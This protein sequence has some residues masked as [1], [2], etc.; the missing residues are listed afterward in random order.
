MPRFLDGHRVLDLSDE[1]GFLCG[2]MLADLGADVIKIEPPD[3][4]PA[5]RTGAFAGDVRDPERSITWLAYN[6]GKRGIT[7]DVTRPRG[8]EILDRLCARAD[9]LVESVEPERLDATRI[10]YA[11][12]EASHP[13]LVVCS[14]SPFGRSG[15]YARHRGGDLTATAMGGNMALTGDGDRAPLR[16]TMPASYFHGGA[17]AATGLL[18][19]L[20]AREAT[21]RGQHVDVSLQASVVAT[22]M[23][24]AS[25]WWLNRQDRGRSGALY[26]VGD[27]LQREVWPCRDGFVTYA[28]RGGPAR[29]PGLVATA[30][31]LAEE[32][33]AAP[34]WDRDWK[35]YNHNNL[36]QAEVDALSE[37]LALLFAR[38]TMRELFAGAIE[39]GLMLAPINDA[40]EIAASEQLA[41]RSFFHQVHDQGRGLDYALPARFAQATG[42]EMDVRGPAPRLGEHN[43]EVYAEIGID[44][45]A[46][47]TLRTEGIV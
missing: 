30:R 33:I 18:V 10:D 40:R 19:A 21:G 1:R 39:R 45:R 5:R 31:W 7:L 43:A 47:A 22:I 13:R 29:V 14:I 6:A 2:R 16:C 42:V 32:G 23:T 3:G 35:A 24:G 27:T 25:Q 28:L 36:T 44:E 46:L 20:Y 4:D 11:T 12:L 15:P 34:A 37:P 8:R 9:A 17:E 26:A 38:K 41:S